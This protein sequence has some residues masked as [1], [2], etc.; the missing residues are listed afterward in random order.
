MPAFCLSVS[1]IRGCLWCKGNVEQPTRLPPYRPLALG[2]IETWYTNAIFVLF[3]NIYNCK[4]RS[5][6]HR[7]YWEIFT[8]EEF[9]SY[10]HILPD[11]HY[12]EILG[13]LPL[14]L[15]F[16]FSTPGIFGQWSRAFCALFGFILGCAKIVLCDPFDV[17][18]FYLSNLLHIKVHSIIRIK[19][20]KSMGLISNQWCCG[21]TCPRRPIC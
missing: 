8:A 2:I 4:T 19:P 13:P 3:L 16:W 17:S 20:N 11:D 12:R 7:S 15:T 14:Q 1:Q 18:Y 6:A 9:L 10:I 5:D 21:G